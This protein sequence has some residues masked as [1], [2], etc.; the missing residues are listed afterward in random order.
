VPWIWRPLDGQAILQLPPQYPAGTGLNFCFPDNWG[1]V[2]LHADRLSIPR[3]RFP[4]TAEL[5]AERYGYT[6]VYMQFDGSAPCGAA[7]HWSAGYDCVCSCLG[8]GHNGGIAPS[9]GWFHQGAVT[10]GRII[11]VH[12]TLLEGHSLDGMFL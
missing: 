2:S 7:C 8:A 3:F 6:D 5:L 11:E 9:S 12:S 10:D 1:Q 4:A